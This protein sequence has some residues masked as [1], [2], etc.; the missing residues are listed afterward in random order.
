M[1]RQCDSTDHPRQSRTL[2]SKACSNLQVCKCEP[3]LL[4]LFLNSLNYYYFTYNQHLLKADY[5]PGPV[6][7]IS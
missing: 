5:V 3:K 6:L 1:Y 7:N 4:R 2:Q